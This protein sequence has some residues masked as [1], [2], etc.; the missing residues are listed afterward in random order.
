M[1][2]RIASRRQRLARGAARLAVLGLL[3]ANAG[4]VP[5]A[6]S[7]GDVALWVDDVWGPPPGPATTSS[8]P[9][10]PEGVVVRWAPAQ[11][12][13]SQV[14][15]V[16]ARECARFDRAARALGP[17]SAAGALHVQR[18]ACVQDGG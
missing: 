18:F 1:T 13:P 10:V 17:P 7:L 8:A 6:P 4:C 9:R 12:S 3:Y 5:P 15:A 2:A 16:A 14:Q 11:F